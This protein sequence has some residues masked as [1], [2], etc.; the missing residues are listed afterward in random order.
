MA[1]RNPG[2]QCW[3]PF[4][5]EFRPAEPLWQIGDY[6]LVRCLDSGL[7]YLS[8]PLSREELERFYSLK[9]FEGEV[10]RKGYS[11][12]EADESVLRANFRQHFRHILKDVAREG[13]DAKQLRLLDYGCA[14]GYFLDEVKD[15][16]REVRGVEVNDAVAE[17]GRRRFGL[18]I[19]SGSAGEPSM[20]RDSLDIITMWDVIEHLAT[21]RSTLS[22][23]AA[24]LKTGGQL[25]LT[26]GDI[27]SPLA[28]VL[29]QHWRLINPPQHITYFSRRTLSGLLQQ[30]GFKVVGMWYCGKRVSLE[31]LL[32]I[33]RYLLGRGRSPRSGNRACLTKIG[34]P[35]NL[36]DVVYVSA[37]KL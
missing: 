29:R 3:S 7:V 33:A 10:S 22:A 15:A 5:E 36:F 4:Y 35:L 20:G 19:E 26:T 16:F 32:F 12:Y 37:R 27:E 34:I 13:K 23:C 1:V 24:A 25:Y 28:R 6:T 31:F 21:P 17:V 2:M 9:Y 8:N 18:D 30:C 14:Y 11:S